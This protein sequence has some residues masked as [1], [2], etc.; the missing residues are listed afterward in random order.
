MADNACHQ[1]LEVG[2]A[3]ASKRSTIAFCSLK[4]SV[5]LQNRSL[6]ETPRTNEKQLVAVANRAFDMRELAF[7]IHE[8][9]YAQLSAEIEGFFMA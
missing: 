6:A 9:A 8:L 3:V 4:R 5:P 2:D 7:A 1:Q